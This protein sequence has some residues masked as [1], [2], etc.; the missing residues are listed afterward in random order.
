MTNANKDKQRFELIP[1]HLPDVYLKI[2]P[3]AKL[4]MNLEGVETLYRLANKYIRAKKDADVL[5]A[6]QD[7]RMKRI[8]EITKENYGLRGVFLEQQRSMLNIMPRGTVTWNRKSLKKSSGVLYPAFVSEELMITLSLPVSVNVQ[9]KKKYISER[10]LID[11]IK[12]ALIKLGV[13]KKDLSKVMRI[14]M[15]IDVNRGK[16]D[17]LVKQGRVKSAPIACISKIIWEIRISPFKK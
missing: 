7:R 15:N 2:K 4:I 13:S 10:I 12:K 6:Q 9:K 5:S 8:I 17:E 16:L 14:N 3:D 11:A 1:T